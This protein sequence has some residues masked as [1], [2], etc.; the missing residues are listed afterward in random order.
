MMCLTISLYFFSC[1][2]S[3]KNRK[4]HQKNTIHKGV[5]QG[6]NL[7]TSKTNLHN[8]NWNSI[9]HSPET[10]SK[11]KTFFKILSELYEKH[12]ALKNFQIKVKDL[13]APWI[14]KGLKK[15]SKQKPKFYIKIL[16]NKSTQNE[17]IY[18][19]HIHLFKKLS[20]KA[21]QTYY[22]FLLKDCQNDMGCTWQ[23]MK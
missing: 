11:N 18:K 22:Q 21:K 20:Q 23:I 12:F 17:Q 16:K 7:M 4:E 13:Q 19:N 5:I 2:F 14:S 15:L 1:F 8:T 6:T 10:N 9:N 3:S